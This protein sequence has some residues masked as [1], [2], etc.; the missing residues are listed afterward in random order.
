VQRLRKEAGYEYTTRITL[1]VGG[2]REALEALRPHVDFIR[3]ETLARCLE[4]GARA[5]RP[6]AE[7][8]L[9]ID[10][11]NVVMGMQRYEERS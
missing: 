7:Q 4:L 10:G 11:Q 8:S 5:P 2:D 3:G 9:E 6:D 1:W